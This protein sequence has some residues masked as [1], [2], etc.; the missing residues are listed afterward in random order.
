VAEEV[1]ASPAC[2]SPQGFRRRAGRD[3]RRDI[4]TGGSAR[5]I[6]ANSVGVAPIDHPGSIETFAAGGDFGASSGGC[7][8]I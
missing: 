6:K 3:R 7:D 5:D 2:S 1:G 4:E 8:K